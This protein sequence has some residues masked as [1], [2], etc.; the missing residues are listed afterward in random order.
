[1]KSYDGDPTHATLLVSPP[2]LLPSSLP[3][4]V[5]SSLCASRFDSTPPLQVLGWYYDEIQL[6]RC[7]HTLLGLS[8]VAVPGIVTLGLKPEDAKTG[9]NEKTSADHHAMLSQHPALPEDMLRL[10]G[11]FSDAADADWFLRFRAA[12]E[13]KVSSTEGSKKLKE[14]AIAAVCDPSEDPKRVRPLEPWQVFTTLG[15]GLVL[16]I[17]FCAFDVGRR[18]R[19]A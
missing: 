17:A 12:I 5:V 16:L 13:R 14:S 2:A 3:S 18:L 15:V 4:Y 1:M 19:G 8:C 6:G 9:G 11:K 10:R 7:L